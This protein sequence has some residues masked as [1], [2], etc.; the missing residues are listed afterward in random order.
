MENGGPWE[1]L[2]RLCHVCRKKIEDKAQ[3]K[4]SEKQLGRCHYIKSF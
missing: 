2:G 1:R 4:I 3:L